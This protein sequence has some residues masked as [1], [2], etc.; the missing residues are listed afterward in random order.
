MTWTL[1]VDKSLTCGQ[2]AL[3]LDIHRQTAR[4]M[5]EDGII[6]GGYKVGAGNFWR[7]PAERVR[8]YAT[9]QGIST[10]RLDKLLELLQRSSG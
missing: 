7:C 9:A 10:E 5:L 1:T 2:I 8:E 4:K 6:P 3:A